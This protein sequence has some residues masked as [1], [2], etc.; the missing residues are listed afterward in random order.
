V[1]REWDFLMMNQSAD[2]QS[3]VAAFYANQGTL[4][5]KGVL[6]ATV[7]DVL[8]FPP[9]FV[10]TKESK[11]N[12]IADQPPSTPP[13]VALVKEIAE[14]LDLS[15]T[16]HYR[17]S[18]GSTILEA[19]C[20]VFSGGG[21]L[22]SHLSA[23]MINVATPSMAQFKRFVRFALEFN[24]HDASARKG[25]DQE[26]LL[27]LGNILNACREHALLVTRE[28]YI[29][30]GPVAAQPG[31]KIAVL[32]GCMRPLVLRPQKRLRNFT[33]TSSDTGHDGNA[34]TYAVVGLCNAHGLNRGE[35]LL[36][37]LPDGVIFI[38]NPSGP[39]RDVGPAFGNNRTGEECVA[40]PRIDWDLLKTDSKEH[41]FVQRAAGPGEAEGVTYYRRPD[42]AYFE[43]KGVTLENLDFV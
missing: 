38:W 23:E 10:G 17:P 25:P 30:A 28:G 26:V 32:L 3:A 9:L 18:R 36:G 19:L 13:V 4:R 37:P 43:R 12:N 16:A 42:A 41:S 11:N 27:C 24:E 20:Y 5:I 34:N 2:G 35:A 14:K 6:V 40:D 7:V 21:F 31:D 39:Y 22:T 15:E 8:E 33:T 29:G 1:K